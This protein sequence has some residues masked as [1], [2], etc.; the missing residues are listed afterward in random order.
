MDLNHGWR[1][2]E[3]DFCVLPN[4]R[5][6]NDVYNFAK[7][8]GF[9]GPAE[10]SFDDSAWEEVDLPHDWVAAKDFDPEEVMNH[11]YKSRG[12]GWY[13]KFFNLE[14]RQRG[15]QILLEF[16][17]LSSEARVYVNG[18]LVR[19][20]SSG[21]VGF[22]ADITDI[23]NYG[24]VPNLVAV[25]I[26]ASAWEGW[27]YEGAGIYRPVWL[28]AKP[29][30]HIAHLGQWARPVQ[31]GPRSWSVRIETEV[32]NSFP[33]DAG[34]VVVSQI[35]G[36]GGALMGE[37]SDAVE[38]GGFSTKT[39]VQTVDVEDPD[40]WSPDS[41]A[42]CK[43]RTTVRGAAGRVDMAAQS[44]GFRTARL[45]PDT[46]FWLNG[47]NLKLKGFCNHQD[48]A[49]VGAAV[50]YA[51]KELRARR[52]KA[53]GANAYR[54]AHN[55]DPEILDICD[56]VGLV[57]MDESRLFSTA[58]ENLETLRSQ[59]R[60]GRNHPS[61][62]LLSIFNEEPLQ[63]GPKGRLMALRLQAEVKTLDPDKIVLGA[64]NG[65]HLEEN[66]AAGVLE[67]VG[68]NY[69][70]AL[71][72][73]F[74]EKFPA[75]PIIGSETS[76]AFATR[77]EYETCLERNIYSSLDEEAAPWGANARDTWREIEKRPFVAGSF[78]W[79][80]FDYRGEPTPCS[81]PSV[82]SFFGALDSCGFPKASAYVYKA[83]YSAAPTIHLERCS[84]LPPRKGQMVRLA[85]MTNCP[86]FEL[87]LNGARIASEARGGRALA[88]LE[89]ED[90]EGVWEA[91]GLDAEGRVLCS[92]VLRTPG[93][94]AALRVELSKPTLEGDGL[95]AVAVD[96]Y[97][98]DGKGA[99]VP[100]ADNLVVFAVSPGGRIAG[101]GNG[102]PNSHEPDKAE[103]RRLFHGAAQA[104]VLNDGPSDLVVSASA[105]GLGKAEATLLNPRSPAIPRVAS[106][107]RLQVGGWTIHRFLFDSMP[108]PAMETSSGD[109]NSFEPI[110]FEDS[111]QAKL[112]G[113]YSKYALYRT[114]LESFPSGGELVFE[115]ILGE[116]WVYLDGALLAHKA[117]PRDGRLA[118][119]LPRR[120]ARRAPAA[121]A[122]VLRNAD[123]D[124]GQGGIISPVFVQEGSE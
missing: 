14:S 25:R 22:A 59:V 43:L 84:S 12:K 10:A 46:G 29:P 118:A 54:C 91:A 30:V 49:G 112:S 74:H 65:G 66:G 7:A 33:D 85:I 67:A 61:A 105:E 78:V 56:R 121:L 18:Q 42:L 97:A 113:Q 50:P 76:S 51:I 117:D 102:D 20:S 44:F 123:A 62:C 106:V 9:K 17:G 82:S 15:S 114:V 36:P 124:W 23:A 73:A 101:V 68:F 75:V 37:A 47:R 11:G 19:R 79:T 60:S 64:M 87:S 109:M 39:L 100:W 86:R 92:D 24:A 58:D 57:A 1:F 6:H 71:Y 108:D 40:L 104:I 3:G 70:Q 72:D 41:P 120:E 31:T 89:A 94:A 93:E 2:V 122:V 38:V 88:V 27:W 8:C 110:S 69:S 115:R 53:L 32:E 99:P 119:R 96:V 98:I 63:G 21:Y 28:V 52:L 35:L 80:G 5:C 34:A 81:W 116:A 55:H 77:G 103:A 90:E 107:A 26:D 4:G 48:H 95:D 45:D 16:E 13:R 83:L 111:P